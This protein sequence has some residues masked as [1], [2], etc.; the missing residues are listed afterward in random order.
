LIRWQNSRQFEVSIS[1][2]QKR[3]FSAMAAVL[4]VKV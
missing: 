3:I 2:I 1:C 4:L